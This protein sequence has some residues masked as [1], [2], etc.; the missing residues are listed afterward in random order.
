M[1]PLKVDWLVLPLRRMNG[2]LFRELLLWFVLEFSVVRLLLPMREAKAGTM[3][4]TRGRKAGV[5]AHTIA[6]LTSMAD[7]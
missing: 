3:A 5:D 2:P 6:R 1:S 4:A 7:Q